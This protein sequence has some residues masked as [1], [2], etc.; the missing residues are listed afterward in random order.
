MPYQ[1][2]KKIYKLSKAYNY[3]MCHGIQL[4]TSIE[5]E[6]SLKS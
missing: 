4:N 5:K 2:E 3:P 6:K 1:I